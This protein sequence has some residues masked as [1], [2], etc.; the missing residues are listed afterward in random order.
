[1]DRFDTLS[2][3]LAGVMLILGP[4]LVVLAAL[5]KALEIGTTT[6]RWYDS[7]PEGAVMALGFSLQLIGLLGICRGI[8]RT[9]PILGLVT[10][11]TSVIGSMGTVFPASARI[12]GAGMLALGF[13]VDQLDP[14][15]G[16]TD[17]A[18]PSDLYIAPFLLIFF[19]NFLVLAFGIWR[20]KLA[21]I[22]V[23]ILL[24]AGT[25]LFPVAQTSFEVNVPVYLAATVL[26]FLGLGVVGI[27]FLRESEADVLGG[28]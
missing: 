3:K 1:M 28:S 17:A 15:F 25:I 22:Y 24:V 10:T 14:V 21:P 9:R 7:A 26:W 2:R 12:L 4:A 11:V 18:S 5:L 13:T 20:T 8:G 27:A 16:G 19:I 6:G 23:P